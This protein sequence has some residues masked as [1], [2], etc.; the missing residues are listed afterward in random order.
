MR[1]GFR[2]YI[3]PDELVVLRHLA[4]SEE[5]LS[6]GDRIVLNQLVSRMEHDVQEQASEEIRN[7][8]LDGIRRFTSDDVQVDDDAEVLEVDAGHWIQGWLWIEK[9]G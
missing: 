1:D 8:R 2:H 9:D 7:V 6:R 4:D 5:T 3:S